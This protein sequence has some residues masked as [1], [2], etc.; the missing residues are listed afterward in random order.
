MKDPVKRID[1]VDEKTAME[2]LLANLDK[3]IDD[4]EADKMYTVDESF[5]IIRERMDNE[6]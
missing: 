3:G 6:L 1:E 2:A 4:M 5:R